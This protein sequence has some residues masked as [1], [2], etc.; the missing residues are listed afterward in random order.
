MKIL[1]IQLRQLG[2][3]ILATPLFSRLLELNH[4]LYI[5]TEKLGFDLLKN[6]PILSDKIIISSNS[7]FNELITIKKIG[8]EK[9]DV[10]IDCMSN[11]RTATICKFSGAQSFAFNKS[12]RKYFYTNLLDYE[13]K[14][15]SAYDKLQFLKIFNDDCD[16]L[17]FRIFSSDSDDKK[18]ETFLEKNKIKNLITISIT[19][20]RQT[21]RWPDSYYIELADM[22]KQ[23]GFD[24]VFTAAKS[25]CHYV[26]NALR[27]SKYD[28]FFYRDSSVGELVSLIKR[29]LLHIGNDSAPKHIAVALGIPSFTIFGASNP[30]GWHPPN[31]PLHDYIQL[32][33]FCQPCSKKECEK[34][35]CLLELKP[36]QVYAKLKNFMENLWVQ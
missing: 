19:H 11:L 3:L 20:K 30:K 22:L 14:G 9:F 36:K 5:L 18:V 25:E 33:I 15:Y 10:I 29:A 34:P 23:D 13:D 6:D 7:V 1:V 8:K 12:W 4:D 27:L 32:G 2:D 31:N 24:L 21:R 16:K 35:N 17:Q 28:H 26:E